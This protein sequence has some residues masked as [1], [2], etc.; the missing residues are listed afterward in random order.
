MIDFARNRRLRKNEAI[1]DIV[2][3]ISISPKDFIYPVFVC[4]EESDAIETPN[5]RGVFR[6]SPKNINSEIFELKSLGVK[7]FMLFPYIKPEQKDENGTAALYEN[8]IICKIIKLIKDKHPDVNII[9]DV[10]L[11]PYTNHGHDGILTENKLDIDN[12]KTLE[13]L[14]RQAL[15]MAKAGADFISPS[16]MMDGRVSVI[17]KTLD[18]NNFQNVGI[19]SYSIKLASNLY[20][21]FRTSIGSSLNFGPKDKLTYQINP[22]NN[23]NIAIKSALDD[24]N[25]GADAIII[26]PAS[27]CLD[28]IS[29]ASK[30]LNVPIFAYQVSGEYAMIKNYFDEDTALK[31]AF[32]SIIAIKRA[33][34]NAIISYCTKEILKY[35][36]K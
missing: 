5:M 25:Q 4:E 30:A 33:G 27:L 6:F 28:I 20:V 36:E 1:R 9:S 15:I 34:A 21:P 14:S 8:G 3:N 18:T 32:E 12:D 24:I 35:L 2:S 23:A 26:K 29:Q 11:D 10:A 17:R 19:I 31:L 7:N 13:A 16:D 22:A